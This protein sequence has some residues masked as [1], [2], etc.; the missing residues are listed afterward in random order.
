MKMKAQLTQNYGNNES[1]AKKKVH[2]SKC[3]HKDIRKISYYNFCFV[4]FFE[5]GF[6]CIALAVLELTL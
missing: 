3:L 4:L 1:S 6:L 2:N 5:T